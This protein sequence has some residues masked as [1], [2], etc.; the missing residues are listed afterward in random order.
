MKKIGYYL[1]LTIILIGGLFGVWKITSKPTETK[2]IHFTLTKN[3][4]TKGNKESKV[5]LIE[6][7]DFQC[8]A[9]KA[10]FPLV[11]Q[12]TDT[13]KD[14]IVIVYRHFPL[15]QHQ[16]SQKAAY[17]AEAAGA[18][19]KFW[20]MHDLL[21]KN[22]ENWA[23]KSNADEILLSYAKELKLDEEQFKKDRES[24]TIKEKVDADLSSGQEAQVNSTPSF[25]LNGEK[26]DNP[27]NFEA[28]KK[29]IEETI[30]NQNKK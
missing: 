27:Q 16:N 15:P 13:F 23:D 20:D 17:A 4:R 10:Y 28:F 12:I 21:F 25:F 1:V 19:G 22:Q 18:Q 7:S 6:Y 11:K 26:L 8:P 5:I 24:K 3:D 14:K 9:C 2:P 30:A 29:I